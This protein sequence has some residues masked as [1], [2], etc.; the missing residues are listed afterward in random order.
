M[1]RRRFDWASGAPA[2]PFGWTQ[3]P[4]SGRTRP[5]RLPLAGLA[6]SVVGGISWG[7]SS[8]A[9]TG[10]RVQLLEIEF[11]A[12]ALVWFHFHQLDRRRTPNF[13]IWPASV[14]TLFGWG[15]LGLMF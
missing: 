3:F 12:T 10:F 8:G 4:P 5:W 14:L 1:N 2:S 6:A 13:W 7:W 11:V 15:P 9:Q